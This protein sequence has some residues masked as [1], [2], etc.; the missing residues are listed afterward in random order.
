MLAV[1]VLA[2]GQP[3]TSIRLNA[4]PD[5]G[6]SRLQVIG[7]ITPAPR[8]AAGYRWFNALPADQA[9]RCLARAGLPDYAASLVA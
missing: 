6:I 1:P 7:R 9:E 5:G 3:V 2:D 8:V 4:F